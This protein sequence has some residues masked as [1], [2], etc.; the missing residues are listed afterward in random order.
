MPPGSAPAARLKVESTPISLSAKNFF[1]KISS[2]LPQG[3]RD[4]L[5][6]HRRPQ[7]HLR[8]QPGVPLVQRGRGGL[9]V[10]SGI[11]F[12]GRSFFFTCGDS[13]QV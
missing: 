1:K 2:P 10:A 9:P 5:G 7:L 4:R 11:A 8:P 13:R 6:F 3:C 12:T